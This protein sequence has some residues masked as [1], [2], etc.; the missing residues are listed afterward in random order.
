MDVPITERRRNAREV[1]RP[2]NLPPAART[3]DTGRAR[4]RETAEAVGF[5]LPDEVAISE[6]HR[7]RQQGHRPDEGSIPAKRICPTDWFAT[8]LKWEVQ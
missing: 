1:M 8:P 2:Q 6:G 5:D 7:Q 4:H 3:G